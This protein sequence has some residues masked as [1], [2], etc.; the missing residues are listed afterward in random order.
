MVI[1]EI[2]ATHSQLII[3]ILIIIISSKINVKQE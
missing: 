3:I 1:I 2:H